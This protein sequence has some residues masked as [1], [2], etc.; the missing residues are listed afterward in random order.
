VRGDGATR[1]A[2]ERLWEV[3]QVPDYRKI[4]PAGHAELVVTLYG[5]LMREGTIPTDWFSR[6]VAQAT[7]PTATSTRSR[8]ASRISD[9]DLR[10]QPSRLA[11]DPEHW[12]AVTR[13]VEDKLSDALHER[14]PSASSTAAPAC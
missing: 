3:C 1:A 10:G 4:S 8:T 9:L 2:V 13:G 14:L 6:Q 12:Q 5:F 7:A 11:A